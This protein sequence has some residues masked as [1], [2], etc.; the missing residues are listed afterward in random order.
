MKNLRKLNSFNSHAIYKHSGLKGTWIC[1]KIEGIQ[2]RY[3][4]STNIMKNS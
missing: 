4:P 1:M 3:N 2:A